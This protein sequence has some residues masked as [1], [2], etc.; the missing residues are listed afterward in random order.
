[1]GYLTRRAGLA[2]DRIRGALVVLA[3]GEVVQVGECAIDR[4]SVSTDSLAPSLQSALLW[5]LRGGGGNYGVVVELT[6][7]PVSLRPKSLVKLY[8][9]MFSKEHTR[10]V[11]HALRTVAE[12]P[13]LP[14][15]IACYGFLLMNSVM[16]ILVDTGLEPVNMSDVAPAIHC[17]P[18]LLM[19]MNASD[20]SLPELNGMF[21]EGNPHGK[22]YAWSRSAFISGSAH[23]SSDCECTVPNYA[24]SDGVVEDLMQFHRNMPQPACTIEITVLGGAYGQVPPSHSPFGHRDAQYEIHAIASWMIPEHCGEMDQ[25]S[26]EWTRG[27]TKAMSK[28]SSAGYL[29]IDSRTSYERTGRSFGAESFSR[30]QMLKQELDPHNMFHHNA[31]IPPSGEKEWSEWCDA[32]QKFPVA[33]DGS[34]KCASF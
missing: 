26:K 24:L 31:N 8:Q 21:D 2:C 17:H 9:Y 22:G 14:D 27:F 33:D 20:I 15:A 23:E 1:M 5:A 12:D 16:V 29:N 10:E 6:L 3:S 28:H 18:N 25:S 34:G 4:A 32:F 13:A 11:L 30:L 7:E 19:T